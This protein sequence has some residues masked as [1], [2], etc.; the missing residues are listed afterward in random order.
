[1]S[2]SCD[3]CGFANTEIQSAGQ[4]Q[5]KGSKI[6][7]KLDALEDMERQIVKS[8]TAVF[9]IEDLDLQAPVGRGR[10]TNIE[11]MLSNILKDLEAGQAQRKTIEPE[12]YEK[13]TAVVQ[14]LE[15]VLS[16][17]NFP[18]T[19]SIDDIAGNSMIERVPKDPADKYSRS[20]YA[21]SSEQN[22][23]LGLGD[24]QT[25]AD[26]GAAKAQQ[27]PQ[28][29]SDEDGAFDDVDILDGV[30]YNLPT[31]CPGC[32]KPAQM[33]LQMVKVPY[34]KDVSDSKP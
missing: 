4:I 31:T 28:I 10:L 6:T 29:Q 25:E 20:D 15:K 17:T 9:S 23:A 24:G 16:G 32:S 13:I 18:F 12:L 2:F 21:R 11:G 33:N 27:I 26:N 7:F 22:A 1:M 19:I 3:A 14:P 8:D 34:F 5:E 30:T